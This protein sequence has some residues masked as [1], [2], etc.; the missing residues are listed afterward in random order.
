MLAIEYIHLFYEDAGISGIKSSKKMIENYG[1]NKFAKHLQNRY[2]SVK[3]PARGEQFF[4]TTFD[5]LV[6]DTMKKILEGESYSSMAR[7]GDFNAITAAVQAWKGKAQNVSSI[8][9]D[10]AEEINLIDDFMTMID[11]NAL[12]IA[13]ENPQ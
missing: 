3:P 12:A 11:E 4:N 8:L 9:N 5:S 7:K 2:F 10:A 1:S 13:L 6:K